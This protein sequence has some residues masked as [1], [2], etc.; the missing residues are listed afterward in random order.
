MH[1]LR[2]AAIRERYTRPWPGHGGRGDGVRRPVQAAA[3]APYRTRPWGRRVA[4]HRRE[5]TT[6]LRIVARSTSPLRSLPGAVEDA[7]ESA[8]SAI[9][10][11][12]GPSQDGRTPRA[13]RTPC[14]SC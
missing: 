9:E 10:F 6:W 7:L 3:A 1:N 8:R 5:R 14:N 12:V 11:H 4:R 13:N 2:D